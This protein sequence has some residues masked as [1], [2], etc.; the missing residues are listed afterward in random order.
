M[1]SREKGSSPKKNPAHPALLAVMALLLL[2][3]FVFGQV[4]VLKGRTLTGFAFSLA[5]VGLGLALYLGK[6]QLPKLG[7]KTQSP[8]RKSRGPKGPGGFLKNLDPVSL[9]KGA[10]VLAALVLAGMGQF[11][12]CQAGGDSTLKAGLWFFSAAAVLLVA[13]LWSWRREGLKNAPLAPSAEWILLGLVLLI[14]VFLRSYQIASLPSGLF[15][16]QG[17]QG[18]SAQR[19]LHEGWRP[20]YVEDIFH[21]YSLALYQL[22]FW[23]KLF[24]AGEVSL[25]LF[26]AFLGILG[27][28][29]V[30]W[31]FR[32]LAGPRVALLILFILAVMRW[33]YLF[34]RNGFPTVQMMLYMFGTLS[35]LLYAILPKKPADPKP[36]YKAA[37]AAAA[38][39]VLGVFPFAFFSLFYTVKEKSAVLAVLAVLA[40]LGLLALMAFFIY[41]SK[42]RPTLVATLLAAGFFVSGFY[43]YQAYKVFPL[44]LVLWALY[45]AVVNWRELKKKWP[46]ILLFA[47]LAVVLVL[48][49]LANPNTR[50]NDLSIFP[51]IRAEHSL[52]PFLEVLSRTAVMFNRQGDPNPRHNLQDYRMLDDVSG[53]LLILGLAYALFRA[54]RRKYFY[55]L[56][57]FFVMSLACVLSIDA[58]HA[59]RLFA[60]T[61]FIAFVIAAPLSALWGRLRALWGEKGE[62]AFLVAAA[63]FLVAMTDQN[64]D[65]YFHKQARNQACWSEYSIAETSAG[66]M[67]ADHGGNYDYYVTPR[68]YNF[69]TLDFLAYPWLNQVKPLLLPD[70]LVSRSPGTSRGLYYALEQG[71]TGVLDML[72]TLYPGGTAEYLVD[73]TGNTVEY[74]YRV[75]PEEAAKAKGLTARFDPPAGG[76][77]GAQID[78]FPDGLPPG[79]YH[80]ELTGNLYVPV[81][82]DYQWE[83]KGNVKAGLKVKG[84]RPGRGFAHLDKGEHPATVELTVPEGV[85]PSL[86]IQQVPEKGVATILDAGSFDSLPSAKGLLGRYFNNWDGA[87]SPLLAEWDP[88]LN[89]TNGNDFSVQP[90]PASV[91][92]AGEIEVQEAGTYRFLGSPPN[93][94]SLKVDGKEWPLGEAQSKGRSLTAGRHSIELRVG[95]GQ[96]FDNFSFYWTLPDGKTEVVPYSVLGEIR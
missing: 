81:T 41:R 49:V 38:F 1:P 30:Y 11:Y 70:S 31:S 40:A 6:G 94:A 18:Y 17:F 7:V 88:I 39:F 22:A 2:A 43:T 95:K 55:A 78:R 28:P 53:A 72:K 37:I 73:P 5:A 74:F 65:V 16:D 15:I 25:K 27:F 63:P 89:F 79:P 20:F 8:R 85:T 19:I 82:G 80:A 36:F 69:Y 86:V 56:A 54:N 83:L 48:P 9:L 47:V 66:R 44:L 46:Y 77:A 45:E 34:S 13:S 91:Q 93:I 12:L 33:N 21:A 67:V 32:Q 58:A 52:R 24:G 68:Y 87:G 14:A 60:M 76:K 61:P 57:G 50:E 29:L 96:R 75:P 35:F 23:F 4:E 84:S 64:F 42:N 26:Y 62:W 92:W 59:N 10:G 51:R 3:A 71:R 90:P